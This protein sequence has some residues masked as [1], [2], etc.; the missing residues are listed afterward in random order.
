MQPAKKPMGLGKTGRLKKADKFDIL[1]LEV[2]K[3]VVKAV[4]YC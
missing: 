2:K 1:H 3:P 4:A